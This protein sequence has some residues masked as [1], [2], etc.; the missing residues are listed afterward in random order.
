MDTRAD[1]WFTPEE[2]KQ[3][4]E[5]TL[6]EFRFPSGRP[7]EDDRLAVVGITRFAPFFGDTTRAHLRGAVLAWV[8]TLGRIH[9][10]RT[11][12]VS[13]TDAQSSDAILAAELLLSC[14]RRPMVQ[15]SVQEL[16]ILVT[17]VHQLWPELSGIWCLVLRRILDNVPTSTAHLLWSLQIQLRRA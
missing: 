10:G 14:A 8:R 11:V 6:Q 17:E 7:T 13:A 3:S 16:V 1:E 9:R 2:R 4:E 15:D 12:R 5:R